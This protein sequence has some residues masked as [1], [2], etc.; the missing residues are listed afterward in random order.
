MGKVSRGG[1]GLDRSSWYLVVAV[2]LFLSVL[3]ITQLAPVMFPG[4][5]HPGPSPGQL[6]IAGAV[7][8]QV[9]AVAVILGL[10]LLLGF[11]F[12]K[13]YLL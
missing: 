9:L 7:R 13:V 4:L 12:T 2:L 10:F 8:D 1:I 11:V 6:R 5:F 3:I